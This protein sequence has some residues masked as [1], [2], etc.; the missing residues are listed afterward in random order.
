MASAGSSANAGAAARFWEHFQEQ[1]GQIRAAVGAHRDA[2]AQLRALDD[3]VREAL[4][5]LPPYDQKQLAAAMDQLR[6]LLRQSSASSVRNAGF[7]FRSATTA[8]P[9]AA[10]AAA[11]KDDEGVPEPPASGSSPAGRSLCFSGLSGRWIAADAADEAQ[12]TDCEL[13]DIRSCVVDLRAAAGSLRAL[14][15]HGVEDSVVVCGALAGSATIR[16]SAGCVVALGAHQ[17]RFEDSH[18][19]DVL[20]HC[21]SH[22]V[23]ERSTAMRFAP[24]PPALS[25]AQPDAG[26]QPSMHAQVH[27]FNWLRRQ[28]SPNWSQAAAAPA[29]LQPLWALLDDPRQPLDEALALLP[30]SAS[31]ASTD[32]AS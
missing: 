7:K 10:A 17:L 12:P 5:Y 3:A 29:H 1:S 26:A 19:V 9:A 6:L 23:I 32:G 30:G 11:T 20:V 8:K 21:T 14:N 25:G 2:R 28:Q 31:V 4:I 13:R 22:P 16:R 27:D 18:N 15:C 24:Y